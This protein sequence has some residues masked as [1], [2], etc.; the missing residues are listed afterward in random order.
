MVKQ[1][2][3][4]GRGT[5]FKHTDYKTLSKTVSV[6]KSVV[7]RCFARVMHSRDRRT[8]KFECSRD[9]EMCQDSGTLASGSR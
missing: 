6:E 5:Y 7:L 2:K 3:K 4:E 1:L 9:N 8:S